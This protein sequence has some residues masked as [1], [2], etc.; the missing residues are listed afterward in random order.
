M[1]G[2]PASEVLFI[3]AGHVKI[4]VPD[5]QGREL[6]L[7]LS[8]PGEVLG[9]MAAIDGGVRS[10]TAVALTK[11][12]EALAIATVTFQRMLDADVDIA[13]SMIRLLIRKLRQTSVNQLGL[14]YQSAQARLCDRIGDLADRFGEP[15]GDGQ[16]SLRLPLTQQELA[17]W[18]GISRQAVVKELRRLRADGVLDI[19]GKEMSIASRQQLA[20]LAQGA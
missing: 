3:T 14:T 17:D 19:E 12:T 5:L 20:D 13:N 11:S 6:M 18:S 4:T 16:L 2:D 9:E 15:T 8:G 1:V 10:A 7:K